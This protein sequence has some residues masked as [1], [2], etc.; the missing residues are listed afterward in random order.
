MMVPSP[1]EERKTT[2]IDMM[3]MDIPG[4]NWPQEK[5]LGGSRSCDDDAIEEP[6]DPMG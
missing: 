3:L 1:K 5:G 6:W 4:E 2:E